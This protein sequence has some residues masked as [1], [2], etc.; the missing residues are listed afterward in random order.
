MAVASSLNDVNIS[1]SSIYLV[2]NIDDEEMDS[3]RRSNWSIYEI[4]SIG[5]PDVCW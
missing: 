2:K 4:A 5:T 3:A 1:I